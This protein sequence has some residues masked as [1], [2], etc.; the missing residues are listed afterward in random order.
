MYVSSFSQV[1]LSLDI[2]EDVRTH[3]TILLQ[4]WVRLGSV[5][6]GVNG[7]S[8]LGGGTVRE[9]EEEEE[10][11]RGGCWPFSGR[12]PARDGTMQPSRAVL[13]DCW[14]LRPTYSTNTCTWICFTCQNIPFLSLLPLA[15]INLTHR[16]Y[17]R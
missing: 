6:G 9:W 16:S 7:R 12:R 11:R 1:L 3:N 8:V 13:D 4:M 17:N 10:E 2:Q 15:G 14:N 5:G